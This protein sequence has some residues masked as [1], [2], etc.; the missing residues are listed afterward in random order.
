[1]NAD[2]SRQ[3]LYGFSPY[4]DGAVGHVTEAANGLETSGQVPV[5]ELGRSP[6]TTVGH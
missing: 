5:D 3:G 1:M 4:M 2:R 6:H